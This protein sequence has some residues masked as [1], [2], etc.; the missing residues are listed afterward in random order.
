MHLFLCR[1]LIF[2]P[3]RPLEGP[4]PL[5]ESSA[6]TLPPIVMKITL[7]P[8]PPS[9]LR[10][11][12]I[13][14]HSCLTCIASERPDPPFPCAVFTKLVKKSTAPP[15][16]FD[17]FLVSFSFFV[18]FSLFLVPYF[19]PPGLGLS[20]SYFPQSKVHLFPFCPAH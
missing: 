6:L 15:I 19:P 1:V 3:P 2:P 17:S 4:C 18:C 8:E 10:D 12:A 16:S 14:T 20:A 13:P 9:R 7:S 5:A 11:G